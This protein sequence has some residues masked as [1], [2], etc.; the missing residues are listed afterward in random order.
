MLELI[1][2]LA[3]GIG[4]GVGIASM[5]KNEKTADSVSFFTDDTYLENRI[6]NAKQKIKS[7]F[8][9]ILKGK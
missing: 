1:I 5:A 3:I 4:I 9:H 2:L 7:K 6:D 8:H